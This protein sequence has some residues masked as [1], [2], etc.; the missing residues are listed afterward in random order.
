MRWWELAREFIVRTEKG[1]GGKKTRAVFPDMGVGAMLK[2]RWEG[3]RH[4]YSDPFATAF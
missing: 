2:N 1:Y 4:S 3:V